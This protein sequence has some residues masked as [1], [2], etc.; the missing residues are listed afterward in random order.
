MKKEKVESILTMA[1]LMFDKYGV[2]KTNMDEIASLAKV[3]KATIYHY[4]GSKEQVYMEVL[5]REV[6]NIAIRLTEAVEQATSPVE[7][8]RAFIFTS[9]KLL[10]ETADI[11]NLR[12]DLVNRLLPCAGEVRKKLFLA[13]TTILQTVLK[14]GVEEGV[15]ISCG[16]QTVR[17]IVY[18]MRGFEF[19]WLLDS[20]NAEIDADLDK[21]FRLLCGG[22]LNA[23]GALYA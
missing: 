21:L 2:Q 13:Q 1:R 17:S 10:K 20:D 15:F 4:F 8:L 11:L 23:K 16:P 19:T 14:K 18:A 5:S 22:I 3:A 9:F 7:K 6:S 12:S